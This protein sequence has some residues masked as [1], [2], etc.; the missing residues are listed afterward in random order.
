MTQE[1][2]KAA[3]IYCEGMFGRTNGKVT[4]GLVRNSDRYKILGVIDSSRQGEDAGKVLDGVENGTPIFGNLMEALQFS[5]EPPS[6]MIF[7][8]A[9]DGFLSKN[10]RI[11]IISAIS[12]GLNIVSGL[13]KF[14]NDDKEIKS[15]SKTFGVQLIDVRKPP[16]CSNLHSFSGKILQVTVP[17]LAVLGT[18][19]A[20]GKRT[21]AIQLVKEL[22]REGINAIFIATGQTGLMQGAKYGVA[23]DM[24]SSG[25]AS[26][27]VEHA[28]YE[29]FVNDHPDII[30]VEGQG[31]LSHP[32]YTSTP[33]IIKG[34]LPN[35][36]IL[37]HPPK[38]KHHGD[39]PNFPMPNIS[40]EISLIE[41]FCGAKVIAIT[42]NHEQMETS[43][44]ETTI[45]EYESLFQIPVTDVL[46][47]TCSKVIQQLYISFPELHSQG[48]NSILLPN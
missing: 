38:R 21:T 35:V 36:I 7:G 25:I 30:I 41:Q 48:K 13:T 5:P 28:V 47:M 8:I 6:Y 34:A 31:S 9:T 26:G 12:L 32:S 3:I 11:V 43:E 10:E 16:N 33:A 15:L 17:V 22:E 27:E 39:F 18:G 37:Q 14:L 1:K 45:I 29:A 2:K 24:L 20:T 44:I 46:T 23:V 40:D 19:C 42:L 4:H